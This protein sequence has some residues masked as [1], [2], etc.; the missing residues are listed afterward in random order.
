MFYRRRI[1][2]ITMPLANRDKKSFITESTVNWFT[3]RGIDV[4]HI[5]YT[6]RQPSAYMQ[7]IDALYLHGGPE[8]NPVYMKTAQRFLELAVEAN[9]QG[10]YFPVWGT[11]HG[12]QTIAMVFGGMP[13]DGSELDSFDALEGH[14]TSLIVPKGVI[15]QSRLLRGMSRDFLTYLTH[16]RHILFANEHGISPKTFYSNRRLPSMFRVLAIANDGRGSD[17]IAMIEAR[18][19]PFYASQFHPEVVAS[20]EPIRAF[21]VGEIMKTKGTRLRDTRR[22][23]TGL[24]TKSFRQRFT[25]KICTWYRSR[26]YLDSFVDSDCY[27]FN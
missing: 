23:G 8:Y 21:F 27:F 26:L 19:Y 3:E 7:K 22:K 9:R 16:E 1:G 20:L 4:I 18:K 24:R 12:F 15:H 11:C 25:P 5:P 2:I 10:Q 14:M 13:L 17:M 6:T